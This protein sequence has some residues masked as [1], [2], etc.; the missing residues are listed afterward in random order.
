MKKHIL[1]LLGLGILFAGGCNWPTSP[2]G[3]KV[4]PTRVIHVVVHAYVPPNEV[5]Q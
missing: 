5:G 2:S 3:P 4:A 1:I